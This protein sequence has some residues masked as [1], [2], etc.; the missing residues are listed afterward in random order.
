MIPLIIQVAFVLF[1]PAL[2]LYLKNRFKFFDWLSPIVLCYLAGIF[3]TNSGI[4]IDKELMSAAA[5]VTVPL[6]IPILLFSSDFAGWIKHSK[7]TFLSFFFGVF[8]VLA[9]STTAFFIFRGRVEGAWDISGMLTAVYT[10]GTPNMSAVGLAL[11]VKEEIFILLNSADV[12]YGGLYFVFLITLAKRVFGFFLPAYKKQENKTPIDETVDGFKGLTFL[13]KCKN[14]AASLSLAFL[15]LGASVGISFLI[16][17][18]I[19][20]PIVILGIS[21]MG[22]AASFFPSI[23]T[24]KGHYP[25]AEYLLL[26]FAVAIGSM[27][28]FREL[29]AASGVIFLYCGFVVFV[30]III[31]VFLSA[32]FRIDTDTMII[33]STAG[34]YGPP[35]VGPVAQGIKNRDVILPGI[36]MGLLGYALG[37]YLGIA[38]SWILKGL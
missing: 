24:L 21:S 8:G 30:T 20:A 9:S 31:H 28:N 27:A 13:E 6:A 33:T 23:R 18:G 3:V 10:G 11:D 19:T 4:N 16:T 14:I 36:A 35:F 17:G 37:N 2:A 5:E 25:C 1:F 15:F 29:A 22:I 38:L 34:I 26:M 12:V 32:L 7:D